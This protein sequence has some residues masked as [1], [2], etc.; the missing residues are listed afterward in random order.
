M[1]GV[2]AR[3]LYGGDKL[4]DELLCEV[5]IIPSSLG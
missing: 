5:D 4:V 2:V 1:V 3:R